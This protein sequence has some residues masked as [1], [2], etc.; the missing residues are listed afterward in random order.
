MGAPGK[1]R[2]APYKWLGPGGAVESEGVALFWGQ[3][4]RGFVAFEDVI[5]ITDAMVDLLEQHEH[6][7]A[8]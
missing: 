3:K 8:A 1:L 7:V 2:V 6:G 4:L 5:E